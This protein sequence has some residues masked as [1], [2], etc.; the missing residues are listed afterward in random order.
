MKAYKCDRCK[1]LFERKTFTL[2]QYGIK[3]NAIGYKN[4]EDVKRNE[5][6]LDLC[7]RCRADLEKFIAGDPVVSKK[8][9]LCFNPSKAQLI[10]PEGDV[11]YSSDS[12]D[13]EK[14]EEYDHD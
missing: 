6:W 7:E 2:P 9:T 4:A 3:K 10:T 5:R 11:V 14:T 1:T 13:L 8:D 12:C